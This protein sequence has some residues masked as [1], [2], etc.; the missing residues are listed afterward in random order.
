MFPSSR[1]GLGTILFSGG[2][3]FRV[4]APNASDVRVFG[5][6]Q[7]WSEPGL[8]LYS[9]SNGYWS[10]DVAGASEGQR[11]KFRVNG[12]WRMDPRAA[13]VTHS[14]GD[15]VV[16][17]RD[18]PWQHGFTMPPW[19]E[20]VIYQMHIG[21]FPDSKARPDS[22]FGMAARDFYHLRDLGVNAIQL[23]PV[24]EFPGDHSGGYNPSHI[25]AVESG[26]GGPKGLK[27]FIDQAH[28]HGLAVFMDVVYNHCGPVDTGAWQFDG[29]FE[30]WEGMDMGGI[31]FY[32]DWRATTRWGHTRP[33]FGRPEVR[34]WLRDNAMTWLQEYRVDGL[35]FDSTGS[36]RTVHDR[37]EPPE[38]PAN[39]GGWGVNLLKWIN[40]EIRFVSPWKT[41][42][43]EDLK[44]HEWL[45]R[46]TGD[47]G[48]GFSTQWDDS[49]ARLVRPALSASSDEARDMTAVA[50]AVSSGRLGGGHRRVI[51]TESHDSVDGTHGKRRM[52]DEIAPGDAEGWHARKRSMIGAALLMTSPGIPMIFQ[53][54][55]I[56]EWAAFEPNRG[57][58]WDRQ[59]RMGGVFI[60]YRDLIRLRRNWF[61]NTRG[62][63]G[64]H[65]KILHA[66]K[67][68]VLVYQRWE[69]GGPG[70]DVIVVVNLSHRSYDSYQTGLP[71]PGLWFV[72]LNSDSRVYSPDF[73]DFP[74]Y[75]TYASPGFTMGMPCSAAI[76]IAPYSC[77][78]LSQ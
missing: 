9:E 78:I 48:A 18:Y 19:N 55:E 52:P 22:L 57:M 67:D 46:G 27:W 77:L 17:S 15:C 16:V 61:N 49:F 28:A 66:G 21:T 73:S 75:D 63:R 40:D 3:T 5:D 31:Y 59:D 1:P 42:I 39:L 70:D 62:L 4:W 43:A 51:Y 72:R 8:P 64:P 33:D 38:S 56:L 35:R 24:L 10:L 68:G 45:T 32:N 2:V 58:D 60:F 12:N 71:R 13:E 36:I 65:V 47:G 76:G 44:G 25:F 34:E 30:R 11:Y 54:Q 7:G 37:D 6:F 14:S 50:E 26:Y 69:N 74:G 53:G 41:T 20:L 29:W 23:L